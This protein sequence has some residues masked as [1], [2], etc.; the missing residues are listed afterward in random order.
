MHLRRRPI[1][2]RRYVLCMHDE[3]QAEIFLGYSPFRGLAAVAE[4]PPDDSI[5]YSK[6]GYAFPPGHVSVDPSDVGV[7]LQMPDLRGLAVYLIANAPV[8]I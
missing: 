6:P 4:A 5:G 8:A 7:M 1:H 2:F 3:L